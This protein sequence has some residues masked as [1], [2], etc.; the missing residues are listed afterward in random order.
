M[1][2][3]AVKTRGATPAS[4]NIF[5]PAPT[6]VLY[7]SDGCRTCKLVGLERAMDESAQI[8]SMTTCSR[9]YFDIPGLNANVGI[10][11]TYL[12][13]NSNIKFD[14]QGFQ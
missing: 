7:S 6:Y 4:K 2:F 9:R 3:L 14:S 5:L 10:L 1:V 13:N 8:L 12:K 11:Y